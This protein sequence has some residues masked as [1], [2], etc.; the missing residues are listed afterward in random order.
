MRSVQEGKVAAYNVQTAVDAA[1]DFIVAHEVTTEATD[2][3]SLLPM[4][5]KA[6]AAVNAEELHIVA[7]AG[8]PTASRLARVKNRGLS[9]TYPP[10]AP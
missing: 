5:Q 3:R 7:D 9:S 4:A 8:Y 1:T 6:H 10:I 2:N